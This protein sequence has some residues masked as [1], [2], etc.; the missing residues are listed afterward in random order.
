N[1]YE[2][3]REYTITVESET[4]TLAVTDVRQLGGGVY[5]RF[6]VRSPQTLTVHI[7]RNASMNTLLS[8]MFLDTLAPL[9]EEPPGSAGSQ[10]AAGRAPRGGASRGP[11]ALSATGTRQAHASAPSDT[12]EGPHPAGAG[13]LNA[14]G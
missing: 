4:E 5:K 1:Y 6:A 2:P 14:R 7:W 10:P 12:G 9:H 3:N 13:L 11:V 8:G